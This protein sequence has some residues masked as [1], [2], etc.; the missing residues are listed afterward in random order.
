MKIILERRCWTILPVLR[1][2]SLPK[3]PAYEEGIGVGTPFIPNPDR[4]E[5]ARTRSL[6]LSGRARRT[7]L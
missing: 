5:Y 4:P 2:I 7:G 1:F 6:W 3:G